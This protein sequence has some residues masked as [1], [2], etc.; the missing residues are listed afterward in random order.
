[1]KELLGLEILETLTKITYIFNKLKYCVKTL[2]LKDDDLIWS[3]LEN[4]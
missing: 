3:K 1:M 2:L 4:V